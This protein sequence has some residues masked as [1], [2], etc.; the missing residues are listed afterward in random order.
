MRCGDAVAGAGVDGG[1]AWE[2][3]GAEKGDVFAEGD[4]GGADGREE[5]GGELAGVEGV[6]GEA[7]GGGVGEVLECS[8]GLK[9]YGEA[10]KSLNAMEEGRVERE[11][12]GG[13]R[14]QI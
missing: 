5:R 10:R 9:G 13:K 3:F 11:T 14:Q 12:V 8:V 6:L 2:V 7:E 1:A 4:G